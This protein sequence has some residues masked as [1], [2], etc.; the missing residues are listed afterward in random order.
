MNKL[1]SYNYRRG[2]GEFIFLPGHP[3]AD[4]H[5]YVNT[6]NLKVLSELVEM[7]NAERQKKTVGKNKSAES[8]LKYQ[9]AVK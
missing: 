1:S 4:R 2:K 9:E 5:G 3:N 7:M 8:K 6:A